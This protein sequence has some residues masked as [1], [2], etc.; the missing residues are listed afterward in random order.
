MTI[1]PDVL[2]LLFAATGIRDP[3]ALLTEST[4]RIALKPLTMTQ[5]STRT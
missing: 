1:I 4:Q 2:R 3:L 5:R